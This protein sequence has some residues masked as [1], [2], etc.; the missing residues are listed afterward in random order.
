MISLNYSMKEFLETN[1]MSFLM[2]QGFHKKVF[3]S[4]FN[5]WLIDF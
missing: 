2:A 1:G 4:Y 3:M 5:D